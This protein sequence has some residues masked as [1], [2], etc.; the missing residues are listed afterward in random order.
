MTPNDPAVR[1]VRIAVT[2]CERFAEILKGPS[3]VSAHKQHGALIGV[4]GDMEGMSLRIGEAQQI[5]PEIWRHL[6]EARAVLA[7]RGVDVAAYDQL[8]AAE[9][10]ALGA[11]V[12]A[13]RSTTGVGQYAADHYVK[14]ANFNR[15]GHARA[16]QACDALMRATPDIP[17]A[18][19]ARAEAADPSI[20]AFTRA[21][22]TTRWIK[23]ALI[24]VVIAAPF[25][26]VLYTR[27][28]QTT[29]TDEAWPAARAEPRLTDG[30]RAQLDAAVAK[31]RE[32]LAAA[33]RAWPAATEPE[34]LAAAAPG[35]P[36]CEHTFPVPTDAAARHFVETGAMDPAFGPRTLDLFRPATPIPSR[37]LDEL[38]R[39]VEGTAQLAAAG[40]GTRADLEGLAHLPTHIVFVVAARLVRPG[41]DAQGELI[42]RA[43]VYSIAAHRLVC[44]GSIEAKSTAD[45]PLLSSVRGRPSSQLFSR[46]L[47]VRTR[48]ALAGSLRALK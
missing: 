38:A 30:E 35:D 12:G 23:L 9:G 5:Y 41:S 19:I 28:Q 15:Q 26:Y 1:S 11:A 43:Y 39:A 33:V 48:H 3:Q 46:V 20:A 34:A 40:G 13:E 47:E 14:S 31:A 7:G 45:D 2:L 24:A 37:R 6:D 8:R 16:K 4:S 22:R 25:A 44:T 21:T 17:W 42:G 27:S 32:T 36:A 18:E 10:N 29:R